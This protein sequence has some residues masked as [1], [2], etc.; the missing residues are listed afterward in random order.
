MIGVML[1]NIV[2]LCLVFTTSLWSQEKEKKILIVGDSLTAGYG[3][4]KEAAYPSQ[5]QKL[6]EKDHPEVKVIGAGSS[7]S[8]SASAISRLKWHLKAK[9]THLVLALGANDGLRGVKLEST[10]KNLSEAID[11]AKEKGIKVYLAGMLLPTNYGKKYR[12][13]FKSLF[14]DLAKEK[15][16]KF[17]PFLL[18]GVG[19]RPELNL[20]DG[21]HPNEKGHKIVAQTVFNALKGD[22]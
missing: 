18:K 16:V 12:T 17:I 9:P 1:I 2:S 8:T 21:I 10:K 11:L 5:L 19:G 6:L 20:A 14:K 7:G 15:G 22:L 13:E 4:S 3:V